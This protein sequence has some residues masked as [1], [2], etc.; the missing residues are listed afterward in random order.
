ME[1]N[2]VGRL[3]D[4]K[5][6]KRFDSVTKEF[7]EGLSVSFDEYSKEILFPYLKKNKIS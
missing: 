4:K 6:Y 2:A 1:K 5:I 7:R 3:S